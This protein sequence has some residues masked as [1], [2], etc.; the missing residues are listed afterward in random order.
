MIVGALVLPP[1]KRRH[2]RRVDD[3]QSR[4][5]AHA[6]LRIDDRELVRPHPAGPH[7]MVDRVGAPTQHVADLVVGMYHR[8]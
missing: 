6:K 7:R 4:D 8:R 3:A 2:D 1:I 5:A